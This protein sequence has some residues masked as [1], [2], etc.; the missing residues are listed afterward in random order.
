MADDAEWMSG[1]SRNRLAPVLTEASSWTS[2][3]Q[4]PRLRR[5][6]GRAAWRTRN[7]RNSV[8][9]RGVE[10]TLSDGATRRIIGACAGGLHPRYDRRPGL[11]DRPQTALLSFPGIATLAPR[12]SVR[13]GAR[14][15]KG[16][17]RSG[18][19]TDNGSRQEDRSAVGVALAQTGPRCTSGVHHL[20]GPLPARRPTARSPAQVRRPMG[21]LPRPL[22]EGA[23][24][25]GH[26]DAPAA[27]L[28]GPAPPEEA[29][30]QAR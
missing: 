21:P 3:R 5:V 13:R 2:D 11:R 19:S 14:T 30:S 6:P 15:R 22:A 18:R 4:E 10:Q 23:G 28:P 24:G 7:R 8:C 27:R 9:S 26:A 29:A 1:K 17:E 25:Q 12:C 16:H 20:R